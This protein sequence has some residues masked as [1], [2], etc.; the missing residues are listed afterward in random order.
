M[1]IEMAPAPSIAPSTPPAVDAVLD[2]DLT[3]RPWNA[4]QLHRPAFLLNVPF[5]FS[6]D[7]ANNAWMIDLNPADR[8][9][10]HTRAMSQFW[11]MYS[12]LAAD[13]AVI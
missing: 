11:E 1:T 6:T 13:A 5:S 7:V 10:N 4:S 12:C 8:E 2:L 9:P 3:E